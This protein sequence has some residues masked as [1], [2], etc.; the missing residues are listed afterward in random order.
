[1]YGI[2]SIEGHFVVHV[3]LFFGGLYVSTMIK[4]DEKV[5]VYWL[6][7]SH[8]IVCI[9]QLLSEYAKTRQ[10]LKKIYKIFI[11]LFNLAPLISNIWY[12]N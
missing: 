5:N 6:S 12:Q 4:E 10:F 8:L 3:S 2:I 11:I 7:A 9:F 1:L